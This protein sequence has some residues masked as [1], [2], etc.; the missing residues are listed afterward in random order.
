MITEHQN[1]IPSVENLQLSLLLQKLS[2][3][4]L[5]IGSDCVQLPSIC[6]PTLVAVRKRKLPPEY[7]PNRGIIGPL[8]TG[9]VFTECMHKSERRLKED[10]ITADLIDNSPRTLLTLGMI[11][12]F[13][14]VRV[15]TR[16]T[17]VLFQIALT[18]SAQVFVDIWEPSNSAIQNP[19]TPSLKTYD[20]STPIRLIRCHLFRLF[21]SCCWCSPYLK[22]SEARH[23][24]ND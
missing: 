17:S 12:M 2:P 24:S 4:W 15:S 9:H 23:W 8:N 16:K 21:C 20:Y 7:C 18:L 19:A 22:D 3:R 10:V 6:P 5:A 1:K 14:A 11:L 13:I